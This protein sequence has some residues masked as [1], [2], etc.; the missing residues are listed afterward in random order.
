MDE[1]LQNNLVRN[2]LY[3]RKENKLCSIIIHYHLLKAAVDG[4]RHK[5]SKII[6]FNNNLDFSV[7]EKLPV[8]FQIPK[9]IYHTIKIR[10]ATNECYSAY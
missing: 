6:H 7:H 2:N 1:V 5:V 4:L 10:L 8:Q 9:Q 3:F